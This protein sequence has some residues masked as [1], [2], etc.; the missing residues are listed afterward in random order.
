MAD[1]ITEDD[2]VQGAKFDYPDNTTKEVVFYVDKENGVVLTAMEQDMETF[3]S[4]LND[5]N[6][7]ATGPTSL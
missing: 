6:V 4:W 2:V 7:E 1:E 5:S 3:L